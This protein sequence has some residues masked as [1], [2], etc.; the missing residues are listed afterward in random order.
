[1]KRRKSKKFYINVQFRVENRNNEIFLHV[2][3]MQIFRH[4]HTHAIQKTIDDSQHQEKLKWKLIFLN[5]RQANGTYSFHVVAG[6]QSRGGKALSL[7]DP[8]Q[9]EN[10]HKSFKRFFIE[11]TLFSFSTFRSSLYMHQLVGVRLI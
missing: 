7:G 1:M 8:K 2:I 6:E 10:S 4:T 3:Y 5:S 9:F 11:L